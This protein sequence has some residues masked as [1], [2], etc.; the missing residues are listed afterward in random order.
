M[1][2]HNLT[3]CTQQQQFSWLQ[4]K[5]QSVIGKVSEKQKK[6]NLNI[7]TKFSQVLN[8]KKYLQLQCQGSG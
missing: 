3:F 7:K 4:I 1:F 6:K 2:K 8:E 5:K